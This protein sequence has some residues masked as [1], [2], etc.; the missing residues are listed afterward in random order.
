[1]LRRMD[2]PDAAPR[3]Q[4][5]GRGAAAVFLE[6]LRAA[7]AP[8]DV[9]ALKQRLVQRGE[10]A[11]AVDA[12]WRRAQ[13]V[14]RRHPEVVFDA[15]RGLYQ[16]VDADSSVPTIDPVEALE[17]LLP[18]R[19]T[20][21]KA[22]LADTVRAA[23]AERDDLE[24][25]LRAGFAG[26]RERRAAKE[27]QVRLDVVRVLADVVAEVEELA[28][29]GAEPA[30]AAERVRGLAQAFGLRAI[31]RAGESAMFTP[32]WHTPIGT[33]PSDD[34]PI[35]V[36][37]PGYSWHDGAEVVL[38]ARAQVAPVGARPNVHIGGSGDGDGG[39]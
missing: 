31:G 4:P 20:G 35:V 9:R 6:L 29:A 26:G 30:I 38:I 22:A 5:A 32:A 14:L 16:V 37:R 34:S 25:R 2:R 27:R 15:A 33:W 28:A 23:L 24:V 3:P 13:P 21:R 7:D 10:P 18:T 39:A 1:M 12:T 8:L 19:M 17:L 36:L 11:A